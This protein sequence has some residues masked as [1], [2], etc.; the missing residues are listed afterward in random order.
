MCN[1]VIGIESA[2]RVVGVV[3]WDALKC[4]VVVCFVSLILERLSRTP[5]SCV[6]WEVEA[7]AVKLLE[8]VVDWSLASRLRLVDVMLSGLILLAPLLSTVVPIWPL[9]MSANSSG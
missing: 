1:N 6:T 3:I 8:G 9:P 7:V 5:D 2:Y 4:G